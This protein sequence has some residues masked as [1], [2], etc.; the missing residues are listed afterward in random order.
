[1]GQ[2]L[3]RD[4]FHE[5]A[6]Q[7]LPPVTVDVRVEP[8]PQGGEIAFGKQGIQIAERPAG[9]LEELGRVHISQGISGKI[10]EKAVRSNARPAGT[11]GRH[12]AE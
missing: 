8:L 3:A 2:R 12:S 6:R 7:V 5:P 4:P 1:M 11:P 9:R 10:T